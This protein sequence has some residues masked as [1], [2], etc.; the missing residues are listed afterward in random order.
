MPGTYYLQVVSWLYKEN[1]L[2]EGQFVALGRRIDLASLH[3]PIFLLGGR[4]DELVAPD[5]LFATA[6]RVGTPKQHIGMATEPCGHLSL[7]LGAETIKRSWMRIADWL[8]EA[9]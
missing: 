5:Q 8:G 9:P 4:D 7:F 2:A 1:R 3:Q 6:N